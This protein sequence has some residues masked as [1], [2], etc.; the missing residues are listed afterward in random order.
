MVGDRR[1]LAA[2]KKCP[3]C[4]STFPWLRLPEIEKAAPGQPVF[5][6]L[7]HLDPATVATG[8]SSAAGGTFA[9]RNF[10]EALLLAK[11]DRV[12]G[13]MFTP[14]NKLA[15][16]MAG[17]PYPDEIRWAADIL[18]WKGPCSEYNR[19]DNLWNARVTSHEPLREVADLLTRERIAA[20]IDATAG[21]LRGAGIA[22]P[23]IAVPVSIR[24]PVKA[25]YSAAKKSTSLRRRSKTQKAVASHRGA[26]PGRHGL[27]QG[28]PRRL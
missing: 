14:F 17:N 3:T 26:F 23:R 4:G 11:A 12:D 28:A 18:D 27:D 25:A 1:V 6:D 19:L 10:R 9:M 24:M 7:G 16:K 5:V 20:A 22:R 8:Q 13:V 15:L 21:M 2:G